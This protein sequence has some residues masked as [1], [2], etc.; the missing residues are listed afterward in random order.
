MSK[1]ETKARETQKHFLP[2][3][4]KGRC[5]TGAALSKWVT[6][7][8]K[9]PDGEILHR[10][11]YKLP[12]PVNDKEAVEMFNLTIADLVRAGVSQIG[13][14][15]DDKIKLTVESDSDG[16][17]IS[18]SGIFQT[19]NAGEGASGVTKKQHLSGQ[20]IA[21]KWR[22]SPPKAKV[23]TTPV[24]TIVASLVAK[25]LVSEEAGAAIRTNDDLQRAIAEFA[26]IG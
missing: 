1:T 17:E 3:N 9:L 16:N 5:V 26:P 25:G 7:G 6:V 8:G 20:E 18:R 11:E 23:E 10:F 24:A 14:N 13:N 21:D 4:Y 19:V 15:I 2:T 22:Y 12:L